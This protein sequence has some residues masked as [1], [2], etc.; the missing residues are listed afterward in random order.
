MSERI[1]APAPDYGAMS[2]EQRIEALLGLERGFARLHAER[3]RLLAAIQADPLPNEDG[4]DAAAKE[5]AR[6]EVALV[7]K[8]SSSTARAMLLEAHELL[9]RFPA[10]LA[11]LECGRLTAGMARRLVEACI[12]IE[13]TTAAKIEQ[14]VLTRAGEQ[15]LSQFAASVRRAVAALAPRK[16][17]EQHADARRQR[18]A[19]FTPQ[20]DGT[21]QLWAT[22]LDPGHAAAAEATVRE[23]ARQ[24]KRD[25]P[26][27]ERTREQREADSLL[28]LLL[29]TA[30]SDGVGGYR[31]AINVTVA[32]STL[33][34]SDEQPGEL[35]GYGPIPATVARALASDPSGTWRRL[36]TDSNNRLVDI[37]ADTYRP[38]V[39]IA[40]L[41][42]A[43]QLS[44][45]F[46]GCRRRALNAELD[47]IVPWSEGG[48]T[49]PSNLQPLCTRHHHLRHEA[50]W[51]V[52][53]EPD[54]ATLWTSPTG[55]T[56][57]R[58]PDEL[59]EDTTRD[60]PGNEAA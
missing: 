21:W 47:H 10:T 43:Q 23:L 28:A 15:S 44:C 5:W 8:L 58:P 20:P 52:R 38:P 12:P 16:A 34:G 19:A 36:L 7:L 57:T 35:D 53:R 55:H 41:V 49:T 59:P 2:H 33:L 1:A 24:W 37:T 56:Y 13:N 32:A 22:G 51:S 60:P 50:G 31:P 14:R 17:E 4:S 26:D 45:C 9:T 30:D 3:A 25:D 27:D 18:Q 46:P 42:R 48:T 39:D 29:G 6:E 54:G 11:L 40:R